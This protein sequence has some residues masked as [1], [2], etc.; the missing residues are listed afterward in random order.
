MLQKL[1]YQNRRG[2][3]SDV[4]AVWVDAHEKKLVDK[5]VNQTEQSSWFEAQKSGAASTMHK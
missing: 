3:C 1:R 5:N 2:W 4:A